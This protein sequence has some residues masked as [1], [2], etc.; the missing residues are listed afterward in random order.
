[1]VT[2]QFNSRPGG[3]QAGAVKKD[4]AQTREIARG[5]AL[6]ANHLLATNRG[7][8]IS[9]IDEALALYPDSLVV[10]MN[11]HMSRRMFDALRLE[12]AAD[13]VRE[14]IQDYPELRIVLRALEKGALRAIAP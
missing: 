14:H 1:M 8:A 4:P 10:A 6:A 2:D 11:C 9:L 12:V 7:S 13:L 5:L 3:G